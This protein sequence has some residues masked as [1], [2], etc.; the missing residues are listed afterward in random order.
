M[1]TSH[2]LIEIWHRLKQQEIHLIELDRRIRAL[3][4]V[5]KTQPRLFDSY[6][7]TYKDLGSSNVILEHEPAI[8]AIDEKLRQLAS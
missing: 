6:H 4:D 5:L 2:E 8:R 7:T 1:N 3:L